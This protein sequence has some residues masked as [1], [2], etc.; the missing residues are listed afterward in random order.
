MPSFVVH[1][2]S[3]ELLLKK[4]LNTEM[5]LDNKSKDFRT[6][7]L[8]A[9][10]T[11]KLTEYINS[12]PKNIKK[13]NQLRKEIYLRKQKEKNITHFRGESQNNKIINV[14]DL[15]LFINKYNKELINGKSIF[16][17]YLF[18]LYIDNKFFNKIFPKSFTICYNEKNNTKYVILKHSKKEITLENLFSKYPSGIYHDYTVLNKIIL[19][20]YPF[21]L[22]NKKLNNNIFNEYNNLIKEVEN[23]NI[24]FLIEKTNKYITQ[25][26]ELNN[27]LYVLNEK[28]VL[29]I[30]NEMVEEF[31]IKYKNY[32]DIC[33]K[34]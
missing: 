28:E 25:S 11:P 17:G 31:Y 16:L 9:D 18:H 20:K 22:E 32:I 12:L 4:I 26:F 24:N 8:I 1:Y 2:V 10:A 33:F 23:C 34:H 13:D 27:K 14:P 5:P 15:D 6:G 30:I 7:N 21:V 19:E 3:G 29:N